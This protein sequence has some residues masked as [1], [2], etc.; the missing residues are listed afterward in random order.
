[1]NRRGFV[2]VLGVIAPLLSFV[3]LTPRTA[4]A[5]NPNILE[6]VDAGEFGNLKLFPAQRFIL[7]MLYGLPLDSR[8]RDYLEHLKREGRYSSARSKSQETVLLVGRR[9]GKTVL[10]QIVQMYESWKLVFTPG[11]EVS[12]PAG[13]L[14]LFH[15][16]ESAGLGFNEYTS[17]WAQSSL[18]P[19]TRNNTLSYVNFESVVGGKV[20]A[21][22]KSAQARGLRGI[23]ASSV[24][25]DEAGFFQN[26][27]EIRGVVGAWPDC[28]VT[29]LTISD[30]SESFQSFYSEAR[31][32]GA[33]LLR[34]PTWDANPQI[35][36]SFYE[37][38][39]DQLGDR[40]FAL[41]YGAEV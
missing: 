4:K 8:E 30:G 36:R 25:L 26:L 7:K 1:M 5:S 38:Q 35:P 12:L 10:G 29:Y 21:G 37:E 23:R 39:R 16:K 40:N 3:G 33:L 13:V 6:L 20:R 15:D 19:Y 22:F 14:S 11:K 9:S 24:I 28:R 2:K 18:R 34:I 17:F 32:R 41:Q 27:S 31:R